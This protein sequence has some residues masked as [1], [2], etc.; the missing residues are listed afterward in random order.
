MSRL[1]DHRKI[2]ILTDINMSVEDYLERLKEIR[3]EVEAWPEYMKQNGYVVSEWRLN[4][5]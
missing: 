5:L 2:D 1:T 4:E 3:K